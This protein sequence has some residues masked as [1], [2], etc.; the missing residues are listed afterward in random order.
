[1]KEAYIYGCGTCERGMLVLCRDPP[2]SRLPR[3][4]WACNTDVLIITNLTW[5]QGKG[6]RHRAVIAICN[7]GSPERTYELGELRSTVSCGCVH[8]EN[9]AARITQY[10]KD[11]AKRDG[12]STHREWGVHRRIMRRCYDPNFK[13][14]KDYG[15]RG[16]KVYEPW[17]DPIQFIRDLETGI[18]PRPVNPPD[19]KSRMPYWTLDRINNNG[20]YEPD[21]VRWT[22]WRTQRLNQRRMTDEGSL[23]IWMWPVRA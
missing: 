16:I 6:R 20:N 23:Y 11:H 1:M 17:H 22:D 7:C 2:G 5:I 4:T 8:R 9:S 19:W 10:N 3:C 13:Q 18:G 15:G 21:N 14:F 12:W